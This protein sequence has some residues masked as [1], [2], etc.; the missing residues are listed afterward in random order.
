MQ[1]S[2]QLNDSIGK[3][4]LPIWKEHDLYGGQK[5][6]WNM[7]R[8]RKRPVNEY[9]Q[10]SK[11][12]TEDW[13][14][15]FE[16]LYPNKEEN[17]ETKETPTNEETPPTWQI[18]IEKIKQ[19]ATALKNRKSPGIDEITN[20]MIKYGGDALMDELKDFYNKILYLQ[21]VQ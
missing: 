19:T 4:S 12:S 14:K 1:K 10:I 20:E 17:T 18:P 16:Q 3:N 13:E 2:S 9:I 11:I 21:K 8:N 5:R 6:I 15:H 7:L